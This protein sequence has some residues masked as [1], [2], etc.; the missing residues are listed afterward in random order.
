M[1]RMTHI[2]HIL[3]LAWLRREL[4]DLMPSWKSSSSR[5]PKHVSSASWPFRPDPNQH[6]TGQQLTNRASADDTKLG[7]A[8]CSYL[9]CALIVETE[10]G[11]PRML[12]RRT[13]NYN[14][15]TLLVFF[16]KSCICELHILT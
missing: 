2:T 11:E 14:Y 4:S 1:H 7:G 3:K 16:L 9:L 15:T 6:R 10:C 5:L 8:M 13:G 12:D